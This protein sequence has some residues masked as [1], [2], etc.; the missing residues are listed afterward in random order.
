[1]L[2]TSFLIMPDYDVCLNFF[3]ETGIEQVSWEIK[4]D[5][6]TCI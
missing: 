3:Y 6:D 4:D 1:M 2:K 5:K